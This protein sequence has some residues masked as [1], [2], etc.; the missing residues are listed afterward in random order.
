M[1]VLQASQ[2]SIWP[3]R[4]EYHVL[5]YAEE[6]FAPLNIH[7]RD[8]ALSKDQLVQFADL[9]NERNEVGTLHP[10]AAVSAVPR[11]AI[12]ELQD[13]HTLCQFI[14][15]FFRANAQSILA[16]KVIMDFRTPSVPPFVIA[17]IRDAIACPS[18]A[19]V[20]EIVVIDDAAP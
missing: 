10:S 17:A 18:A 8:T 7:T 4:A 13:T 14:E 20:D 19:V 12:R 9:V 16:N 3:R 1:N 6:G 11:A 15:D 5:T 2:T